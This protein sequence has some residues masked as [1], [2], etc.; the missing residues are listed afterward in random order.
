MKGTLLSMY[1][2]KTFGD[3][4]TATLGLKELPC[5]EKSGMI[6]VCLTPGKTFDID[7]WLGDFA[8]GLDT[9][10]L[11]NWHLYEQRDIPGPGWKVTW[12]GYFH[13][14]AFF[15]E[16][17][18]RWSMKTITVWWKNPTGRVTS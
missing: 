13:V 16:Y 17:R 14:F 4:D 1:G 6:W 10:D 7:D 3:V 5:P 15:G 11:A 2:G 18:S 9:L 12:D 8:Y